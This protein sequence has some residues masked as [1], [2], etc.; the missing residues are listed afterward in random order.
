MIEPHTESDPA[1]LLL[2]VLAFFGN[3]VG[4]GPY[5]QVENTRHGP[6]L[7]VLKVGDSSKARKGTGEDRAFFLFRHAD[8][9][10]TGRR[11]HTGLSS[12]EGVIWEVRDPIVK[13]LRDGKGA[14]AVMVEET[15]DAGVADKRLLVIESEFSGALRAM[16]R[17]GNLLSRV[18]RDAW[19]KGNLATMTKNAPARATGACISIIG[20]I[21]AAE[22]RECLDRTEMANGFANRFVFACVRRSKFLPF[23]G[24][25]PEGDAIAMGHRLRQAVQVAREICQVGMSPAAA[26]AWQRIYRELSAD[27]PGLLGSLTARA[28]AQVVRLAMIYALIAGRPQIELDH[29]TAAVAV[30]EFSRKSVEYIFGDSLGDPVADTILCA[31]KSAGSPG[32]NSDRNYQPV[33]P[34]R[35]G[36]PDHSRPLRAVKARSGHAA[37]ERGG[38]RSAAG[39]LGNHLTMS[40]LDTLRALARKERVCPENETNE[41][42]EQTHPPRSAAPGA[43]EVVSS[44]SFISLPERVAAETPET[45]PTVGMEGADAARGWSEAY[46]LLCRMPAPTGF[47][48]P[49]WNRI[50]DATDRFLGRWAHEAI[51]C[52]WT[53]LDVFGCHP[54]RPTARFDCMGLVLLLDR[55]EVVGIDP[56]GADLATVS[57]ARQRFR[58]R[59]LPAG[60]VPLWRLGQQ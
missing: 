55:C 10:W 44:N 45:F 43:R 17:E 25:L 49:R 30:E 8:D 46:A 13:L 53:N 58:R 59:S 6:N 41:E 34:K 38:K 3:C 36:K 57:G 19:D 27:R 42:Y 52:G 20:H 26:D 28:E 56:D 23:G 54:D 22:L 16:Q 47:S 60:T 37:Q 7:F 5:Y 1:G 9:Q 14:N 21:T 12:G 15:V 39:N 51:G 48:Q 31:L 24:N 50:I 32:L 2:S 33:L 18:L 11:I 40:A 29:L 4:H 35:T